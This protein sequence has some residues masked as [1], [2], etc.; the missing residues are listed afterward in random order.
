MLPKQAI[1]LELL[2]TVQVLL[3]RKKELEYVAKENQQLIKKNI[4]LTAVH[5]KL[6]KGNRTLK[7]ELLTYKTPKIVETAPF[8]VKRYAVPKT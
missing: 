3:E 8:P 5:V 7:E 1:Y 4:D 6:L 2:T